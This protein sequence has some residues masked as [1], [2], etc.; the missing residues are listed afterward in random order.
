MAVSAI[1]SFMHASNDSLEADSML[2]DACLEAFSKGWTFM[3]ASFQLGAK[4]KEMGLEEDRVEHLLRQGFEKSQRKEIHSDHAKNLSDR[5]SNNEQPSFISQA[6]IPHQGPHFHSVSRPKQLRTL[7]LESVNIP[8]PS[9]QWRHDFVRLL[10]LCYHGQETVAISPKKDAKSSIKRVDDLLNNESKI[11]DLCGSFD[12]ATGGWIRL[13]ATL[14]DRESDL[15]RYKYVLVE[16]RR[17][18]MGLQL[19]YLRGLNLPCEA[20]VNVGGQYLQA[21]VKIDA[22]DRDDFMKKVSDV[23]K[24]CSVNNFEINTHDGDPLAFG[25]IPG[26]IIAGRQCYLLEVNVGAES[27]EQ[28]RA[29]ANDYLD[30]DPLIEAARDCEEIPSKTF[31]ILRHMLR[32]SHKVILGGAKNSGKSWLAIDMALAIA[33]GRPWLNVPSEESQV[34]F[35]NLELDSGSFVRRL[36]EVAQKRGDNPQSPHIDFLHLMGVD[37]NVAEF[38]D[39]LVKRIRGASQWE[40]KEYTTIFID[41]MSKLPGFSGDK[42]MAT[43]ESVSLALALDKVVALTGAAVVVVTDDI[44]S[45]SDQICEDYQIQIEASEST[46]SRVIGSGR[47]YPYPTEIQCRFEYPCFEME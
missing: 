20:I 36:W 30:G 37:K 11:L 18:S 24:V 42:L 2:Y 44:E 15:T 19:A 25:S 6:D 39:L 8:W 38:A 9:E 10:K 26:S 33:H 7:N 22:F 46:P 34:L 32:Q 21:W 14:G 17:L 23:H 16:S 13:N 43:G 28:W 41:G 12:G 5:F 1:A 31:E 40:K 27:F 45:V 47:H 35:V 3:E 4:A 29:W